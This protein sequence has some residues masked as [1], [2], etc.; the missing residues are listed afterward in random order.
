MLTDIAN[1]EPVV[2]ETQRRRKNLVSIQASEQTLALATI[3]GETPEMF[4][5]LA[6][7]QR[8]AELTAKIKAQGIA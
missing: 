1:D 2:I 3:L 8:V 7:D 4:V 5:S 6:A